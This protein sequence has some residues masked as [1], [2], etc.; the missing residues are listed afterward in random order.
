[1]N[2]FEDKDFTLDL[3]KMQN[4]IICYTLFTTVKVYH[5]VLLA[6]F[7]LLLEFAINSNYMLMP[8]IE[9]MQFGCGMNKCFGL[10]LGF[11][12]KVSLPLFSLMMRANNLK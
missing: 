5:F 10:T 1:M 8:N 6:L 4:I 9:A 3:Y 12:T 7:A 11:S 2:M